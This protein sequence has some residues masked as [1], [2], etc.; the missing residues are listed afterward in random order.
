MKFVYISLE[1]LTPKI[2][3]DWYVNDLIEKKVD[4]KFWVYKN[5]LQTVFQD[6]IIPND[7][8]NND[9][10]LKN[11]FKNYNME[12]YFILLIPF[13]FN[14]IYLFRQLKKYNCKTIFISWGAS[15][16]SFNTNFLK[17]ILKKILKKN[18]Y[19]NL[20]KYLIFILASKF[21]YIKNFDIVFTSGQIIYD[22]YNNLK[23]FTKQS[24]LPDYDTFNN[25]DIYFNDLNYAVFLD[26]NLPFHHDLDFNKFEKINSHNYLKNLNNFLNYIEN[27]YN[28]KI[29]V[30]LHPSAKEDNYKILNRILI[31]N[32]TAE[33]VKGAKFVI[34]H[35]SRSISYAIIGYKP[36][37][38]IYNNELLDKYKDTIYKEIS[39]LAIILET[40]LFNIDNKYDLQDLKVNHKLYDLYKY[41]Y[42]VSKSNENVS[43]RDLF[44]NFIDSVNK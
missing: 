20:F 28:I 36:I 5:V 19:L 32:R 3:K 29:I 40:Q 42:V 1:P 22:Y 21:G 9:I 8:I 16:L 11:R 25:A 34:S 27:R 7:F 4:V 33:L 44:I 12:T 24:H 30:A 39:N 15:P 41:N 13:D 35:H 2:A 18:I 26:V 38:F 43:S 14:F 23:I 6:E 31:K 17:T 37:I 10:E